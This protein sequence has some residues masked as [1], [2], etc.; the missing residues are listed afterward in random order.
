MVTMRISAD[1]QAECS[2]VEVRRPEEGL[3]RGD[4]GEGIAP[5]VIRLRT[6]NGT[7]LRSRFRLTHQ[8]WTHQYWTNRAAA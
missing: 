7:I 4:E 5:S 3:E 1:A 6:E 2:A 8:Y